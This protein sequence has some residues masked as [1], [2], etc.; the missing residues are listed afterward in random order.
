VQFGIRWINLPLLSSGSLFDWDGGVLVDFITKCGGVEAKNARHSRASSIVHSLHQ[1]LVCLAAK[2]A[3]RVSATLP[4]SSDCVTWNLHSTWNSL[5]SAVFSLSSMTNSTCNRAVNM[6]T[7]A[8]TYFTLPR[9]L[10]CLHMLTV[11]RRNG[12][13]LTLAGT[14][15]KSSDF[16]VEI[17]LE[18]LWNLWN[19]LEIRRLAVGKLIASLA[20]LCACPPGESNCRSNVCWWILNMDFKLVISFSNSNVIRSNRDLHLKLRN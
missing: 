16:L 1:F 12:A 3:R 2:R 18:Y 4:T 11:V 19:I 13:F 9:M 14:E 10:L 7:L 20:F 6:R 5:K 17:D 8:H 15:Q